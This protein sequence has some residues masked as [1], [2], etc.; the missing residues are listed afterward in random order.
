MARAGPA[1]ALSL[2][3]GPSLVSVGAGALHETYSGKPLWRERLL[4]SNGTS[5]LGSRRTR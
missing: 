3:A 2:V 4:P 5:A 1:G